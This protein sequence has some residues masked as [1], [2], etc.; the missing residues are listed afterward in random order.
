MMRECGP[1]VSVLLVTMNRNNDLLRCLNTVYAQTYQPLEIVLVDNN[2]SDGTPE[3]ISEQFPDIRIIRLHK[4]YGCPTARNIGAANC[5]GKYIYLLDDDGWLETTAIEQ[6]V[7]VA[8]A[9]PQ[10]GAISSLMYDVDRQCWYPAE[11]KQQCLLAQFYG[12]CTLLRKDAFLRVGGFPDDFFRN[13]EEEYTSLVLLEAGYRCC[14]VPTSVMYHGGGVSQAGRFLD[15][16][17]LYS[18]RNSCKTAIRLYPFPYNWLRIPKSVIQLIMSTRR[19][20]LVFP[21]ISAVITT[22]CGIGGHRKPISRTTYLA[23]HSIEGCPITPSAPMVRQESIT[24]MSD[25]LLP[26]QTEQE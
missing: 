26:R 13:A 1:L 5:A 21:L 23:F 14:V 2:S 18:M 25:N 20:L 17:V 12:T 4:N 24:E 7:D 19:P 11:Y 3:I 8:E 10:L 6:C 22:L 16:T 15:K 9:N